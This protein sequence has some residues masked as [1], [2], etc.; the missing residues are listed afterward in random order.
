MLVFAPVTACP[1]QLVQIV[2]GG[3]Y[4]TLQSAIN[5]A[6]NGQT[7]I[8]Q[9]AIYSERINFNGKSITLRS[10]NPLNPEIVEDTIIN[11]QA[12][13]SA[14][15]FASGEPA[16]AVLEGFTITNGSAMHGAGVICSNGSSPTLRYNVIL[17]NIA[18]VNG[19]GV[20]ITGGS[21]P[22]LHDN[23][24]AGNRC[25]GRG[26]GVFMENAS[27]TLRG[28]RIQ[29][30]ITQA[31]SGGGVHIGAGTSAARLIGNTVYL[32]TA[33]FG[34]GVHIENASPMLDGNKILGNF[35]TPR[36]A[37]VSC[38]AG[39]PILVNNVI[40]GNQ[41]NLAAAL[42]LNNAS[43]TIHHNTIV[44]NRAAQSAI[45][46]AANN[47]HP[48]FMNNILAHHDHGFALHVV[49]AS[50]IQADFNCFF[51]NLGGNTT[52][53]VVL[54]NN[55]LYAD[56][57]L[58]AL[59]TWAEGQLPVGGGGGD[60]EIQAELVGATSA[61]GLAEYRLRP[62]RERFKVNVLG[63]PLNQTFV[64]TLN[65]MNV[66]QLTTDAQGGGGME[67]DTNDGNFPEWFPEVN[68]CD[69]VIVGG[70]VSGY[71]Q[72]LGA[73]ID[74]TAQ[75]WQ[76]GDEHLSATSPCRNAAMLSNP[77]GVSGDM[78]GQLRPFALSADIGADE[79]VLAGTG[80]FNGDDDVDLNDF[81]S[82]QTCWQQTGLVC[83]ALDFD[84]NGAIGPPDLTAFVQS[85]DG[86][87]T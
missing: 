7:L 74:C 43:P 13:G 11:A 39:S 33:L 73:G 31:S 81:A 41:S 35:G 60:V 76:P 16:S 82:F 10:T 22:L 20:H 18:G 68:I 56:P 84:A 49:S 2:G 21:A 24:I 51:Q 52:G 46:L 86:P 65:G 75:I 36:G 63:M 47:S 4:P 45:V 80:D 34:G 8:A 28:N 44:A 64:V 3:S 71:F 78:D 1:A 17:S 59:G 25:Q 72:M 69:Q 79:F 29:S 23:L 32:N 15:T 85:L 83:V 50:S 37:G 19:G 26:A 27:P 40:A 6:S 54:G 9:P 77:V 70:I 61:S 67:Y 5:A 14:V 30:N 48:A 58:V 66:G 55:N 87:G 38:T 62:D 42:D 12:L 57:Q 53:N